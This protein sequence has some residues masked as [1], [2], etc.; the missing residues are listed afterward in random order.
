MSASQPRRSDTLSATL[1]ALQGMR[2]RY[3]ALLKQKIIS[4]LRKIS[5]AAFESFAK[6]LLKV[7]GFEE[8][9]VTN[10]S[11]DGGIDGFGKLRVGL[12]HLNVAFQCKRWTRGRIQRTEIDRFR[13]AAQGDYDQGIFFATTAFTAGAIAASRK[14]GAIPIVMVDSD[15]IVNLMIDKEFGVQSESVVIPS[16]ALDLALGPNGE[17]SSAENLVSTSTPVRNRKKG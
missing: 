2:E 3:V 5:P 8:V 12:A 15:L 16:Y 6:E 17:G 7:Y 11:R 9:R 13:G 10:I 1:N 4:E 14:H